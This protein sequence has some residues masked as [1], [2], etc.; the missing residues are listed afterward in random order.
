[1]GKTTRFHPV[2]LAVIR[3]G[4]AYGGITVK[5]I[6]QI[7]CYIGTADASAQYVTEIADMKGGAQELTFDASLIDYI[8]SLF[9]ADVVI[10][11]VWLTKS[12]KQMLELTTI[13]R[14]PQFPNPTVTESDKEVTNKSQG[15]PL[16]DQPEL[17]HLSDLPNDG[18]DLSWLDSGTGPVQDL[19]FTPDKAFKD[20]EGVWHELR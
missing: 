18:G 16:D 7:D 13:C 11:S 20:E 15:L 9:V 3:G 6:R 5:R 10:E 12:H 14:Q 8:N 4:L 2:S 1:M 19:P 17:A